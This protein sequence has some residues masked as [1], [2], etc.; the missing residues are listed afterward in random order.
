MPRADL[1]RAFSFE[2]VSKKGAVFDEQKLEW[3]N[4]QYLNAMPPASIREA[5]RP[6]LERA[7]LWDPSLEG[8]RREW[9]ERVLETL[10]ARSRRIGDFARDASVFLGEQFEYNP[11]AVAKH[12]KD[13]ATADRMAELRK[14]LAAV[15]PFDLARTEEALRGTAEG[16]G[17]AAAKLIHPLRVA[18]TGQAVSPGIFEVL[19]LMGRERALARIDRLLRVL[20]ERG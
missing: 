18:L 11:E 16:L 19:V 1:T 14:A 15:E 8:A 20:R 6:D 9:F 2:A 13:P 3:L 7:G 10:K 4:S 12:L 5:I 17:V